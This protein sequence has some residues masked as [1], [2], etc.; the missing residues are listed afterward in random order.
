MMQNVK[1]RTP[2]EMLSEALEHLGSALQLLDLAG[3][4]S[5]IGARLDL[6]IHEV[7]CAVAQTSSGC[8]LP[9]VDWNA[10]FQ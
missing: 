4:P 7:Y 3:A 9:Q 2:E 10:E 5:Q 1:S 6:V 8:A